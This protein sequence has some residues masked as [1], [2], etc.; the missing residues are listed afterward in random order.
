MK[1]ATKTGKF[2]YHCIISTNQE[3]NDIVIHGYNS[4]YVQSQDSQSIDDIRFA[5]LNQKIVDIK[6]LKPTKRYECNIEC[7]FVEHPIDGGFD[8]IFSLIE[9]K[10]AA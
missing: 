3:N 7:M 9:I 5:I 1:E 4:P 6:T 8:Q 10:E 2:Q